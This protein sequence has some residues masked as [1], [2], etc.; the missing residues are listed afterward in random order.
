MK[1]LIKQSK[2]GDAE[3]QFFLGL[4][5]HNGDGLEISPE[6]A[7]RWWMKAAKQEY[8]FA[9]PY[10]IY[11][12]EQ[13]YGTKVVKKKAFI[14]CKKAAEHYARIVGEYEEKHDAKMKEVAR[15]YKKQCEKEHENRKRKEVRNCKE[16][17]TKMSNNELLTFLENLI[18]ED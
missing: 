9:M 15:D 1:E 14:Y 10:L 5:Y 8:V 6:K 18:K 17:L 3:A 11:C 4:A 16:E 7:F 2:E 12:Y 13:G